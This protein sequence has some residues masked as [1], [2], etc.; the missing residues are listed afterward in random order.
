MN[1]V[2]FPNSSSKS[3]E[4]KKN[5]ILEDLLRGRCAWRFLE[6][7]EALEVS[8]TNLQGSKSRRDSRKYP[9]FMRLGAP[10]AHGRLSPKTE[11]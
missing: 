9:L 7:F 8:L 3:F 10:P 6:I 11:T 4:I 1:G 2:V 5:R